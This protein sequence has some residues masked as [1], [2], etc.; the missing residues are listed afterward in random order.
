M[1]GGDWSQSGE[2]EMILA[3]ADRHGLGRFL[4]IGAADGYTASNTRRLA[5][6]GWPGV[7]VEPAA[8]MF[9]KLTEIYTDHP[10]IMCV[11]AA[12]IADDQGPLV[13]FH[14]T[15]D[16]VSTTEQANADTWAELVPFV[17]CH[18]AAVTVGELLDA[19]PGPYDLVSIDTEGTSVELWD[20]IRRRRNVFAAGA[21]VIVEAEDGGERWMIQQ[22]CLD[23]WA[24]VGVTP[25]NVILERL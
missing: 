21:L 4:D 23:G 16:L 25:N 9:D 1:I 10:D 5:L 17:R 14:Y 3:W 22:A 2:Q 6:D 18:V 7:C 20:E 15:R 8:A 11:Q 12:L 19:F 24:R 13:P